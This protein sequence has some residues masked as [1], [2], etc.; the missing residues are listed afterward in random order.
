[1][2]TGAGTPVGIS[3]PEAVHHFRSSPFEI[4]A[5]FG[6]GFAAIDTRPHAPPGYVLQW[7]VMPRLR[8]GDKQHAFTLGAGMS[9]GEF[10]IYQLSYTLWA[11][12]EAG[13]EH[14]LHGGLALRYFVGYVRGCTATSCTVTAGGGGL[15][16]PYFGLG[17][18]YAF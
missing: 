3:G 16:F 6:G 18:G 17:V 11:N 9:G 8:L 15:A 5:G 7:A 4:S 10:G 1:M 12:F 2:I 13:G 14:W